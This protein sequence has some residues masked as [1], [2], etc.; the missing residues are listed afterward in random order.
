MYTEEQLKEFQ[1]QVPE[2]FKSYFSLR[3][4]PYSQK[5]ELGFTDLFYKEEN[6][7][8]NGKVDLDKLRKFKEILEEQKYEFLERGF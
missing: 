7:L 8:T 3:F 6:F 4:D 1:D 5:M 2:E